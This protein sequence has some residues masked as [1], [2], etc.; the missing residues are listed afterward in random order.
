MGTWNDWRQCSQD[1]ILFADH[2]K[3]RIKKSHKSWLCLCFL[4]ELRPKHHC[5]FIDTAVDFGGIIC[6][7]DVLDQSAALNHIGRTADLEVFDHRDRIA[8]LQYIPVAVFNFH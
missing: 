4:D 3:N 6:Q 5:S 2:S 7:P 8:V 1:I